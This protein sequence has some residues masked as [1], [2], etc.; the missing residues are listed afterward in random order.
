MSTK[1]LT[2]SAVSQQ[3]EALSVKPGG[4]ASYTLAGTFGAVME[5]QRKVNNGPWVTIVT[6]TDTAVTATALGPQ[7]QTTLYRWI[8]TAYTSGSPIGT[9]ADVASQIEAW[10]AQDGS[11][12]LIIDEDGITAT[13][14]SA[15]TTAQSV[16]TQTVSGI[17]SLTGKEDTLTAHA[18]GTQAAALDLS[19]TVPVHI[20]TVCATNGDSVKMPPAVAGEEHLIW[21]LGAASLQVFGA[22]TSTINGEATATGVA[23]PAGKAARLYCRTSGAAGAWL[24]LLGA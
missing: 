10:V 13:I 22:G 21:N 1:S 5:L 16:V 6:S 14:K 15:T 7:D 3:T 20:V 23:I 24:M 8:C 4:K 12:P 19:A 2:F 9:I 18:G 17:L 11:K